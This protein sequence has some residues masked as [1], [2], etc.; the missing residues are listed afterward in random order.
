MNIEKQITISAIETTLGKLML[1]NCTCNNGYSLDIDKLV[2][3][4]GLEKET[5]HTLAALYA[6]VKLG[7]AA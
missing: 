1:S 4:V 5:A 6:Q 3:L 2:Y 7:S